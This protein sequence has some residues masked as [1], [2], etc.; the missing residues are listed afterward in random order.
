VSAVRARPGVWRPLERADLPG[1]VFEGLTFAKPSA[2]GSSRA[3]SA[4][5]DLLRPCV[6]AREREDERE[7]IEGVCGSELEAR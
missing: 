4:K 3:V 7:R 2:D 6:R 1:A 5:K